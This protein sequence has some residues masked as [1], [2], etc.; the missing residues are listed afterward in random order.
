MTGTAH[1][2]LSEPSPKRATIHHNSNSRLVTSSESRVQV[3]SRQSTV[4]NSK[5]W[6][7]VPSSESYSTWETSSHISIHGRTSLISAP[8]CSPNRYGITGCLFPHNYPFVLVQLSPPACNSSIYFARMLWLCIWNDLRCEW[9]NMFLIRIKA[10]R[11]RAHRHQL[12]CKFSCVNIVC[13]VRRLP[14]RKWPHYWWDRTPILHDNSPP[15]IISRI[16]LC[17]G[18]RLTFLHGLYLGKHLVC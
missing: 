3:T 11:E 6:V 15:V 16:L 1:R 7:L 17:L 4:T 14:N 18:N 5:W 12:K 2:E 8:N 9:Q 13:L 10:L